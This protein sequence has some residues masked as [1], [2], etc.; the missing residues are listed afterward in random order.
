MKLIDLLLETGPGL[1]DYQCRQL[2]GARYMRIDFILPEVIGLDAANKIDDLV[3]LADSLPLE[4]AIAWLQSNWL[5]P[6]I[7]QSDA[8]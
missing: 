1:A 6:T 2:L 3:A 5:P 4:S 7:Q 8:A